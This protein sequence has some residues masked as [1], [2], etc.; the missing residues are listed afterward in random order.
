MVPINETINYCEVT[1]SSLL[2]GQQN[3][4]M[5]LQIKQKMV[6]DISAFHLVAQ[7]FQSE[8]RKLENAKRE[9][10]LY[11]LTTAQRI[12]WWSPRM[13]NKY[14]YQQTPVVCCN[15]FTRGGNTV[16]LESRCALRLRYAAVRWLHGWLSV[17]KLP[18]KCAVA[19][20]FL[21]IQLLNSG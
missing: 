4:S 15:V 5:S 6:D 10:M 18:L 19:V 7:G 12:I 20:T 8:S 1:V 16:R 3:T 11:S 2:Q 9:I 21:C 17:L 13:S 14:C